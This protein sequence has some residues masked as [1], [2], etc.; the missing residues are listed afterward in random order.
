M[1]MILLVL[2]FGFSVWASAHCPVPFEVNGA[3][4]CIGVEWKAGDKM[5]KGALEVT[6]KQSP[7][8]NPENE[9]PQKW[10]YSR[11]FVQVWAVFS[12]MVMSDELHHKA[13]AQWHYDE[14]AGGFFLS[15]LALQ[16][17]EGC[18]QLR[19]TMTTEAESQ[20]VSHVSGYTNLSEE[21]NKKLAETCAALGFA[22]GSTPLQSEGHDHH[23]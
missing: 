14:T 13:S 21:Q 4:Y 10:I 11:A 8:L 15:G 9:I 17:M 20:L 16:E 18:W 12:Y 1:K 7:F 2:V 6:D 19:W 23:H 5:V 22:P 3:R